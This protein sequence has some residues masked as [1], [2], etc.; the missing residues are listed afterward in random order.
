MLNSI[1]ISC[2]YILKD[3]RE[4]HMLRQ[5]KEDVEYQMVLRWL[6]NRIRELEKLNTGLN[7]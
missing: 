6:E 3:E 2:L 4:L 7:E 5:D 1:E